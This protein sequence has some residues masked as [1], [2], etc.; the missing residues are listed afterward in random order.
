MISALAAADVSADSEDSGKIEVRM[1]YTF[2]YDERD[3][4]ILA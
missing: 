4:W 3:L 1:A 2:A